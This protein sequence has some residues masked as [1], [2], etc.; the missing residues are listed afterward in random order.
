MRRMQADFTTWISTQV[1]GIVPKHRRPQEVASPTAVPE[2][3]IRGMA[4]QRFAAVTGQ[5]A[6]SED[7][8]R[9]FTSER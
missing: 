7:F 4:E 1:V 8:A 3:D 6:M 2:V 9:S 5:P